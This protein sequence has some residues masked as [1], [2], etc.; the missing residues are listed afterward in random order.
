MKNAMKRQILFVIDSLGCGGAE[1][2][3]VSLL[4]LL[5]YDKMDVDVLLVSRGGVFEQY[6]PSSVRVIALPKAAG[7][8]KLLKQ[9]C[10]F[11]LWARL[12]LFRMLGLRR[13]GA[14]HHWTAMKYA[15]AP[16]KKHY[17]AAV[18]WHQGFPTYYVASKVDADKKYAWV[19][20]DLRK[21]GYS[22]S[23][24]RPYY[25]RFERVAAVSEALRRMLGETSY[26]DK[27]RLHTVYDILNPE[28]IRQ[29]AAEDGVDDNLPAGTLR[30]V[31]AGRMTAQKNY[32]LAV[33]TARRLK[34]AG[35]KFRWY[36]VGDGPER[37]S[38]AQLVADYGLE[39][40][41]S[42]LG[43]LPNP[44]RRMAGCDIYVQTS[45]FEGFCLTLRE[46]RIL[47]KPVVST[48]FPVVHDQIR[49]GEN[50]LIAKMTPESVA[51]KI[52]LLARVPALRE[53]LIAATRLEEDRTAMTEAAKVNEMLLA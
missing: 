37:E 39:E 2:S 14:E 4:P 51:E 1:K 49:D 33:E 6:Q 31:T 28:L 10:R 24:N 43:M 40:Y 44:Y 46:A 23:F 45:S 12:R 15:V 41:V 7:V 22:E 19:N 18:A 27:E 48:D 20:I 34:A 9:L 16:L 26:V 47:N 17:D 29:L 35:L 53:K 36:F 52:L 38:V 32:G 50:G 5:E 11:V 21:A 3:L 25:N 8:G 42:L 13:H 30:I